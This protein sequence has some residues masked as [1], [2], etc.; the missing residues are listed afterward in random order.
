MTFIFYSDFV[1]S[2]QLTIAFLHRN[3]CQ[4]F[5]FFFLPSFSS[6]CNMFYLLRFSYWRLP[7]EHMERLHIIFT[8]FF[9][10][11]LLSAM[12]SSSLPSFIVLISH[13]FSSIF[14]FPFHSSYFLRSCSGVSIYF[15]SLFFLS[16]FSFLLVDLKVNL[17]FRL[18]FL[19]FHLVF[20][21]T[22]HQNIISQN[23][24]LQ[25]VLRTT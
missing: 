1:M 13:I 19:L 24:V 12:F 21:C 16:H 18:S 25:N 2:I 9:S 11:Y 14:S 23:Y 15:V 6:I 5:Q 3:K 17:F 7:C 10:L 22:D 8:S 4:N 20:L